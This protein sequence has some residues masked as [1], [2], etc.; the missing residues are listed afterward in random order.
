M[1]VLKVVVEQVQAVFEIMIHV[2]EGNVLY[3][4]FVT[5]AAI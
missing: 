4:P 1:V 3:F 5:P 2:V